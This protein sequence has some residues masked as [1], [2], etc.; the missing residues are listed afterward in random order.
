MQAK[1]AQVLRGK[2]RPW[3][4]AAEL[5]SGWNPKNLKLT[6]HL[7]MQTLMAATAKS[8]AC[9]RPQVPFHFLKN[10][11]KELDVFGDLELLP[12]GNI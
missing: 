6:E 11:W 8:Q 3:A 9:P 5:G 10:I 12:K 1:P 2:Q 7:G 4:A